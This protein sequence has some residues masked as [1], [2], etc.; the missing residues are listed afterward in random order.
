[1]WSVLTMSLFMLLITDFMYF[2]VRRQPPPSLPR[3]AHT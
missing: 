3:R 1:M 2:E